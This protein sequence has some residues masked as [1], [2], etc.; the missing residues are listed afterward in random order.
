MKWGYHTIEGLKK[1]ALSFRDDAICD[2]QTLFRGFILQSQQILQ[3]FPAL[4]KSAW[5]QHLSQH[6]IRADPV[7]SLHQLPLTH[8]PFFFFSF[9]RTYFLLLG[10]HN[11]EPFG[12]GVPLPLYFP[13]AL[14]EVEQHKERPSKWVVFPPRG[15]TH[16]AVKF[17]T[18]ESQ[19]V[20]CY[21]YSIFPSLYFLRYSI[22]GDL[23][24]HLNCTRSNKRP[25]NQEYRAFKLLFC[26]KTLQRK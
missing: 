8:I 12:F 17:S 15:S 23:G 19:K 16:S 26:R 7:V 9:S 11:D 25:S 3:S 13:R 2:N 24:S 4:L 6:E 20:Y 18:T 10:I 5:D 1:I 21:Y 22:L 14:F